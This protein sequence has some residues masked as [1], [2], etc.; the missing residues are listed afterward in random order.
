MQSIGHKNK[1]E[2]TWFK[3]ATVYI[4]IHI[5]IYVL[6]P[7][8]SP[9][10]CVSFFRSIMVRPYSNVT[11]K[12]YSIHCYAIT[13]MGRFQVHASSLPYRG[14]SDVCTHTRRIGYQPDHG[15]R[16]PDLVV[17]F[18]HEYL[19]YIL[20]IYTTAYSL[21]LLY[22]AYRG[23]YIYI[24]WIKIYYIEF[25]TRVLCL[26]MKCVIFWSTISST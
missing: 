3:M 25:P 4:C 13:P 22:V 10:M 26:L 7:Y 18:V 2:P 20:Y 6:Y 5:Y 12:S 17:S 11:H 23:I 24:I 9:C 16:H 14:T 15:V 8:L 21:L 19:W 1:L